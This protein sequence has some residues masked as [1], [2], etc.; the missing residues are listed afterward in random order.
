VSSQRLAEAD[1][2]SLTNTRASR[3]RYQS[4]SCGQVT[5]I[6]APRRPLAVHSNSTP[7]LLSDIR[8]QIRVRT[9]RSFLCDPARYA[10]TISGPCIF[11]AIGLPVSTSA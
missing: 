9:A 1:F 3:V 6:S 8:L 7:L 11:A 5:S 4:I 2:I 10:M